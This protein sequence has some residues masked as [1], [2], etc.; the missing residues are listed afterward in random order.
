MTT[1]ST[2]AAGD[3]IAWRV[4]T[5]A[6]APLGLAIV[7]EMAVNALRAY[8]LGQQ[9]AHATVDV[10][11][12]GHTFPV[13]VFGAVLA[14]AAIALALSQARAAW[15]AFKPGALA[16]QR[17]IAAPIAGLLLAVS[18]TALALTLLEAQRNKFGDEGGQRTAYDDAKGEYDRATAELKALGTPRPVSVIQNEVRSFPI[19]M[20]IW[21]R[22]KECSDISREDTRAACEPILALYKERGAAARKT[23]LEQKLPT[24]KAKLDAQPRPAEPTWVEEWA[25]SGWA[26]AFGLAAVLIATFGAPLFA[27]P[28]RSKTA[29]QPRKPSQPSEQSDFCAEDVEEVRQLGIG[30]KPA[31]GNW[32]NGCSNRALS[33]A[34]ALLDI[35]RRLAC[36]ETIP[37]QETLADAWGVHPGTASKWLKQWRAE[38]CVPAPQRVGR[39]HRLVL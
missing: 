29:T 31:K 23:E 5:W 35:T 38:G 37:S 2:P 6:W 9:H 33:K 4:P 21:R 27:E 1:P 28:V 39:C 10:S 30:G 14:L 12:Y 24:L 18:V 25:A 13:S 32:G 11:I 26:W 17:S 20:R 19:D 8:G 7:A 3:K 16:R 36:G 34:E 15:V 22:S